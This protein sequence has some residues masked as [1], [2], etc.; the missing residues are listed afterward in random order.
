MGRWED[1]RRKGAEGQEDRIMG[2]WAERRKMRGW[3]D[4]RMSLFP[5]CLLG[6]PTEP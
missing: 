4:R 6:E 5:L 3:M 2:G 1:R